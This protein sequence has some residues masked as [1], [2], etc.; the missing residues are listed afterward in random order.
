MSNL[1]KVQL[2]RIIL[3]I[4]LIINFS[5]SNLSQSDSDRK[6]MKKDELLSVELGRKYI[7]FI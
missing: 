5:D 3:D 4:K 2:T 1:M 6:I 7:N